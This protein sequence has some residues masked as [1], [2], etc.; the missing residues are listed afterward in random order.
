[1]SKKRA[2]IQLNYRRIEMDTEKKTNKKDKAAGIDFG[3]NPED[4]KGM[5]EMMGKCC[6]SRDRVPD[7]SAMMKTMMESFCGPKTDNTKTDHR[8]EKQGSG[9]QEI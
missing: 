8:S 7:R 4:F 2:L 5:F 6:A 3:C 9:E 1:M